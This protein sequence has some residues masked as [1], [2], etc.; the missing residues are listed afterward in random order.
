MA[1][2]DFNL[3]TKN[4]L[5]QR[6]GGRCSFPGCDKL[7]WIAGTEPN[8]V[9]SIGIAAHIKA[10]SPDGPRYDLNQTTEQR[11]DITNGIFLCQNH[12]KMID[13]D[14]IKYPVEKL[15]EWKKKHENQILG[16]VSGKFV[17]PEINIKRGIGISVN[18][19]SEH[20][21][22]SKFIGNKV[23]HNLEIKNSSDF[24]YKRIGFSIQFPELIEHQPFIDGP[25]GFQY[26]LSG[27]NMILE[28]ATNGNGEVKL[29][30]RD[31]YGSFILEGTGLLQNQSINILIKS[32][33]DPIS[34]F[35]NENQILFWIMGE[36]SIN[37]GS[38]LESNRFTIPLFYDKEQRIVT[39]GFIHV[40]NPD[41]D[42]YVLLRRS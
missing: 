23:E 1:R 30:K 35:I 24:E 12:A 41:N 11:K 6:A 32:I 40:S 27:E 26:K 4:K 25:P 7:C 10:A 28:V 8:K 31:C 9:S 2:D 17:L 16:E 34:R 20:T 38:I 36:I 14:E 33:P 37:I 3:N 39:N 13:D 15:I 21:I 19:N 22:N 18:A 29:C 5:A 42:E